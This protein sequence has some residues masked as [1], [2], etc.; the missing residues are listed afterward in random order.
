MALSRYE[1]FRRDIRDIG[2]LAEADVRKLWHS[3]EDPRD[4]KD[5]LMDL[6]PDVIETYGS[7]AAT[8]A[9]DYYDDL[10]TQ[11]GARGLFTAILPE[12]PRTGSEALVAWA[13]D[14][15]AD[16]ASFQ[17]HIYA[18]LQ[19]R[20]AN[21][22]R[23]V[24]TTSSI[25]DPGARGWM[26]V[27]AGGCDFCAMLV[28]RGAVYSEAT[29]DFASHDRCRCSAAPAFNPEQVKDVKS[30]FVYSAR[31]KLD[32]GSGDALPISEADRERVND[33]IASHL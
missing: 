7:A 30:E 9:A 26:R 11:V 14:N 27:G 25:A 10:R 18:G 6:L 29:V 32:P 19:K 16:S 31:R 15:A 2:L 21:A 12:M 17:S 28:S 13:L 33:W 20:I 24:V 22:G 23:D 1:Q 8:V 3:L 4:A 5:A